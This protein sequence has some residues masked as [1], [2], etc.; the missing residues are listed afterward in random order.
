MSGHTPGATVS[1]VGVH[2]G[3]PCSAVLTAGAPGAGVRFR[4]IVEDG[5]SPH[6]TVSPDL[7]RSTTMATRVGTDAFS[8]GTV[9]HLLAACFALELWDVDVAVPDSDEL[10]F[11]DGTA[12]PWLRGLGRLLAEGR[13]PD[14]PVTPWAP[15]R[16]APWVV[17]EPLEV[18]EGD[19]V[20]RLEPDTACRVTCTLSDH[21]GL[22]AAGPLTV[23]LTITEDTFRRELMWARTFVHEA[24]AE[25]LKAAGYGKGAT[26]QNTLLI[27][28]DGPVNEAR[29]PSEPVRHK[30]VDALGDLAL[31]GRRFRGHLVLQDSGHSLHVALAQEAARRLG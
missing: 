26:L 6:F 29:G 12:T 18:R 19:R 14:S 10:P 28:E 17:R 16:R 23:S 13:D 1:G 8:V 20:A 5:E 27:G 25:R 9:E 11:G 21:G 7:V 15:L 31:V 4:R 3:L 30:I 2:S 22:G 24:D